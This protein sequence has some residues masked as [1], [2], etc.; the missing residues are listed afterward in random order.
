MTT[1]TSHRKDQELT[2]PLAHQHPN[3]AGIAADVP[4]QDGGEAQAIQY[5]R[6]HP[7]RKLA[8]SSSDRGDEQDIA[9]PG[10]RASLSRNKQKNV[11]N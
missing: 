2:T 1:A 5:Y 7:E 4:G 9:G 8:M 11:D 10:N 6:A 3:L